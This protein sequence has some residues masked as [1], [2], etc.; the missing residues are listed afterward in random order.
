ML[1]RSREN[2]KL[3][4]LNARLQL[5]GRNEAGFRSDLQAALDWIG[6]YFEPQAKQTLAAQALLRQLQAAQ[7]SVELPSLSDS[8][9]TVRDFKPGP[10]APAPVLPRAAAP[11][12]AAARTAPASASTGAA[13]NPAAKAASPAAANT[14]AAPSAPA[15][16]A[17]KAPR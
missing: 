3:R 1:F 14:P 7:V 13:A 17:P 16:T 10:G 4:L 15:A 12:G 8:L 9:N 2:L 6:R 11:A 5:I